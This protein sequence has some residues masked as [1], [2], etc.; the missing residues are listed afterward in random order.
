MIF[1]KKH[2]LI[3]SLATFVFSCAQEPQELTIEQRAQEIV[4][5]VQL[6]VIPNREVSVVD[7]GAIADGK[8]DNTEV[9]KK[10]IAELSNL[11]GGKLVVP[12]GQYLT[13]PIHLK[14]HIELHLSEGSEILFKTDPEAYMPMVKT[15]YEGIELYNF[16]P[17]IYAYQAENIAV[18]GTGIL[19]GQ[20]GTSHW[21]PW[22]GKEV[23]GY[24]EGDVNQNDEQNLPRLRSMNKNQTPVEERRFGL[25]YQVRPSFFE[26]YESTRIL[27]KDVTIKNAPFWIVHPFK[28]SHF[29]MDGVTVQS[30]G[31]NNDGCDPEYTNFVHINNCVFDTGDD[32]IAIKSGRNEDGRRNKILSQNILVQNSTMKDGHG[33]VV[34]GSEISAGV[35]NVVVL[36]CDM[37]SPN[38]DRAIRLKS[39]TI[40]GG[41]V[42]GLYVKN[43]RIGQVKEAVL[44]VNTH[45]GIYQVEE[46]G[47]FPDFKNIY[48][49]DIHAKN[50]GKYGVLIQGREELPVSGLHFKNVTIENTKKDPVFEFAGEVEFVNTTI[51]SKSY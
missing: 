14:S 33:G 2:L 37:D 46:G 45:Y 13:G 16:S 10:A 49:E 26:P 42:D 7:Y 30:H 40:R 4:D 24:K 11:G 22:A 21:W 43:I 27:L 44:R 6:P 41:G 23:Y 3:V 18:T 50:G 38:L 12:K 9:F 28:S 17:L 36:N 19:N 1:F 5:Q 51:N 47:F 29:T 15:S 31:P 8:S 39:N 35:K 48:L 20:A 34:M 25:G 32:C